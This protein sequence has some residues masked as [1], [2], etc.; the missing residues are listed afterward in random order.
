[1]NIYMRLVIPAR[2]YFAKMLL[3]TLAASRGHTVFL[4]DLPKLPKRF[5][6]GIYH[7]NDLGKRKAGYLAKLSA[8]GFRTTAHDEEHGLNETSVQATLRTRFHLS[9]L[10]EVTA[11]FAWGEWDRAALEETFPTV[12]TRFVLSGSPRVDFWRR[13]I[14][15]DRFATARARS[16]Q[17]GGRTILVVS[18]FGPQPTPAWI[19]FGQSR[20][21]ELGNELDERIQG[22]RHAGAKLR[23]T[24]DFV[25]AVDNIAARLPDARVVVRPH[26][27]EVWG[28]LAELIATR[29]NVLVT[30]AGTTSEWLRA[31][32]LMVHSGSTTG[33]ESMVSRVR[34]IAYAPDGL[35]GGLQ[36][37]RFGKLVT[38]RTGLLEA[39]DLALRGG[40]ADDP[41]WFPKHQAELLAQRIHLPQNQ[42]ASE[43]IL[44]EWERIGHDAG[45]AERRAPTARELLPL[46]SPAIRSRRVRPVRQTAAPLRTDERG[47][48]VASLARDE[49]VRFP[50]FDPGDV[51]ACADAL[52]DA[53]G[54][55]RVR[56]ETINPRL[57]RLRL[58]PAN[59]RR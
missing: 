5:P 7:T 32:D 3:G 17:T 13:D 22:L 25:A 52:A 57:I 47:S 48:E 16:F 28:G 53:L 9:T 40:S 24:A 43:R 12:S 4:G 42:L 39:I 55:P 56:A 14:G 41:E 10:K 26:P 33:F 21:Q 58:S 19:K 59:L 50:P 38:T 15:L 8:A 31:C 46:R 30:R 44:E 18:N 2:E 54:I 20:G 36:S 11:S 23:I 37:N 29:P 6:P 1:M 34:T 49:T 27:T 35:N 45:L 51:Q